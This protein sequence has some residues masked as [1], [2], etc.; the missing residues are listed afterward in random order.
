[1]IRDSDAITGADYLAI[2]DDRK[3]IWLNSNGL[4]TIFEPRMVIRP[5]FMDL[6]TG[7][8]PKG[9]VK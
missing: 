3:L 2:G 9:I 6:E 4:L 8:A 5:K 7:K 1:M